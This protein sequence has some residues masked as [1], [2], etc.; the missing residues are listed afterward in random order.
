MQVKEILRVKG[1]RL[2]STELGGSIARTNLWPQ[3]TK[4]RLNAPAKNRTE[5]YLFRLV[6]AGK[7]SLRQAQVKLA[8]NWVAAY[9]SLPRGAR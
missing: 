6:C 4:G 7:L 1:N 8:K 3:P 2:I 5:A 9:R